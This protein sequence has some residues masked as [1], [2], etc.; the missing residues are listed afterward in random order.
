VRRVLFHAK[1][2]YLTWCAYYA[3]NALQAFG[4]ST[5]RTGEEA[6]SFVGDVMRTILSVLTAVLL[7]WMAVELT[8]VTV[9]DDPEDLGKMDPV[10]SVLSLRKDRTRWFRFVTG[11][12]GFV[13]IT[14][15][16]HV[17]L[18]MY[19]VQWVRDSEMQ[20]YL[21]LDGIVSVVSGIAVAMVTM[22]LGSRRLN[23]GPLTLSMLMLYAVIQPV[24]VVFGQYLSVGVAATTLALVLK[25]LLWLVLVWA[26][27]SGRMWEYAVEFRGKVER[28]TH[29]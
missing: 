4:Q 8:E 9:F 23:P 1:A 12:I 16:L 15:V 28:T 7:A 14:L 21:T 27:S 6:L 20:M 17:L 3:N 13:L 10:T 25:S 2:I 26:L 22:G 18:R 24:A 19:A 11:G 29:E 5:S